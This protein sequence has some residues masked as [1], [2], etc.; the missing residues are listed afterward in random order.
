[1]ARSKTETAAAR[2][3]NVLAHAESGECHEKVSYLLRKSRP[4]GSL[5]KN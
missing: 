5:G 4:L 1:M 2:K 3:L